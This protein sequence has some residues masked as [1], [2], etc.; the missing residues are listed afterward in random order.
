[1]TRFI[2]AFGIAVG[3]A[4]VLHGQ[5]VKSTTKVKADDAKTVV[6]TGCVQTGTETKSFILENAIPV[7]ET[8]TET[9]VGQAGMPETTTTTTTSYVLVPG[10][11]IDLEPNVGHKVEVTAV[12]IPAGDGKSKIETRTKTEIEGQPDR[13]TETKEKVAQGMWPQLRVVSMKHLA[14]RCEP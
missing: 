5:D 11:K 2:V 7:K 6:Y 4:A 10:E 8:K 14:D 9:K 3:C 13:K 12:L 1:M